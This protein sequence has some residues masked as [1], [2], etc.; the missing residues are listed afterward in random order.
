MEFSED[1]KEETKM[2]IYERYYKD[3]Y[4][5]DPEFRQ[6]MKTAQKKYYDNH[7]ID[8][9]LLEY[10]KNYQKNYYATHPE[11]KEAKKKKALERYYRLKAK[12][13]ESST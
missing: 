1:I 12:K 11:Y 8:K 2:S 3:R 4:Q 7:K 10:H 6:M 5:T 9:G 13:Q